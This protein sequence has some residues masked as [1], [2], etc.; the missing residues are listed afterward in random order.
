M[1]V[2]RFRLQRVLEWQRQQCELAQARVSTCY[3]VVERSRLQLA[4]HIAECLKVQRQVIHA[5]VPTAADLSA[6]GYFRIRAAKLE[7]QFQAGVASAEQRLEQERQVMIELQRRFRLL[8][9][10]RDRKF[11]EYRYDTARELENQAS[12]T[13]LAKW[14]ASD[15]AFSGRA[16]RGESQKVRQ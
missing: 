4:R 1:A 12:D 10:L 15:N 11:E 14:K 16:G 8:E 3:S 9:K 5:G 2:F 7:L 6:L 13:Y